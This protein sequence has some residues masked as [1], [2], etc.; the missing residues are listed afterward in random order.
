MIDNVHIELTAYHEAAH[1]IVALYHGYAV[2]EVAVS[3][4]APGNGVMMYQPRLKREL[5]DPRSGNIRAAW[6]E[7]LKKYEGE[8]RILLAGPLSEAKLLNTPLRS[9]GARS[10]LLTAQSFHLRLQDIQIEMSRYTTLPKPLPARHLDKLRRETRA[11]LGRPRMWEMVCALASE[12][13][14]IDCLNADEIA[15]ILQQIPDRYG[16]LGL[17]DLFK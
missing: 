3:L 17:D 16:Q 7:T 11:L 4:E 1:A 12:L 9:L 14:D 10:D 6:L 2:T 13:K 15:A 5:S 8:I